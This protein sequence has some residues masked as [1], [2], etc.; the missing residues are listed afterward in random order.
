MPASNPW[1]GG[2]DR[3]R[4]FQWHYDTFGLPHGATRVLTNSFN[5][6]QAFALGRRTSASNATSR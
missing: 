4:T 1:F 5:P 3:F 2:R 6:E